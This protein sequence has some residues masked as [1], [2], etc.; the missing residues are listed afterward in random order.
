[1]CRVAALREK[2][3]EAKALNITA[4]SLQWLN[5]AGFCGPHKL[6]QSHPLEVSAKESLAL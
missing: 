3:G 1:V 5:F 6:P 2:A 4:H